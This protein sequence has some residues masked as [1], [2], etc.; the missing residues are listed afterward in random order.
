MKDLATMRDPTSSYTFTNFLHQQ[1]RLAA[2]IN[3]E[4]SIPSRREWSAY[5]HWA[6]KRMEDVVSYSQEV[7][8]VEP[9]EEQ[10]VSSPTIRFFRITTRDTKSGQISTRLAKNVTVG[11]GGAPQVPEPLAELY[12]AGRNADTPPQIVHSCSYLP[13]LASLEPVLRSR[14]VRRLAEPSAALAAASSVASLRLREKKPAPLRFAVVGSGQSAAEISLHLRKVFPTSHVSLVFRASAIVPSDDSAF[15]NA[16]AF[17]P[18][19]T[20]T[21][22][23]ATKAAR[24]QWLSEFRRTNYSV[25]RQDVLNE[26]HTNVYDQD[27]QFDEPWPNADGPPS[28]GQLRI[29][30]NTQIEHAEQVPCGDD[31][32]ATCIALTLSDLKS[33]EGPHARRETYDA[34]FLAT[35][36]VRGPQMLPFLKP[37]QDLYPRLD[38]NAAERIAA[39]GFGDEVDDHETLAHLLAHE[40]DESACERLR[41]RTR[42][43]TRDYRLVSYSSEAFRDTSALKKNNSH[44]KIDMALSRVL[45]SGTSSPHSNKRS[46]SL[47]DSSESST[48]A[49]G[50]SARF[51]KGISSRSTSCSPGNRQI[52]SLQPSIYFMGGNEATHGLSDSLLSIVAHRAGELS[53]S[54]LKQL[55]QSAA[56]DVL[57]QP[58]NDTIATNKLHS[59]SDPNTPDIISDPLEAKFQQMRAV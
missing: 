44:E 49:D 50:E 24:M 5:L 47:E 48:L 1:G 8:S 23:R 9:V 28:H 22:W 10:D 38:P 52:P 7:L 4:A 33:P 20:S 56:R 21:F 57:R 31:P 58:T 2:F 59:R 39:M 37:M 34:V 29:V 43:I 15:V 42:G 41:Q 14:E 26:L 46:S 18:E 3:R 51:N 54:L 11:V 53:S 17:D 27:L 6:A 12:K 32:N 40:G 13:S 36:F 16:V 45:R 30:P 25:V 35:G 19:R 55:R